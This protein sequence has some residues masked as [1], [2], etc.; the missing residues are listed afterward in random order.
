MYVKEEYRDTLQTIKH[1]LRR[2][3]KVN[4]DKISS[5]WAKLSYIYKH[6]YKHNEKQYKCCTALCESYKPIIISD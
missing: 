3:H 5:K 6:M 2:E 1:Y 4:R